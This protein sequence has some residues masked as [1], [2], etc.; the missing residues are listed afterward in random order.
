[1]SSPIA[2]VPLAPGARL[3]LNAILQSFIATWPRLP[4]PMDS[5]KTD[6]SLSFSVGGSTVSFRIVPQPIADPDFSRACAESWL[7][8]EAKKIVEG[9]RG[10]V[11][12]TTDSQE[13]RLNQIK[14]LS[15]A[16]TA[17]LIS[18]PG[19]LG[20]FWFG[21]GL[22]VSPEMFRE[23]CVQMLPDSLPLYI[24]IDFHVAKS[25]HG[26]SIGYTRGLAQFGLM[27][28]ET[29]NAQEEPD[30]LRERF[31]G[32]AVSFIENGLLLKN[33]DSIDDEAQDKIKVVYSDS[34]FGNVKRV[35]RLDYEAHPKS[36]RKR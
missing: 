18:T 33:G 29:L 36:V 2:V 17:L 26:R 27:E 19:T 31:F 12:I 7:W 21:G 30:V 10:H 1:M 3:S 11:V 9:H 25:D 32:L 13:T 14:F 35:M 23:F 24:W 34:S 5:K 16:T 15:L 28:L 8:P 6:Q 20:V 22:V 4:R